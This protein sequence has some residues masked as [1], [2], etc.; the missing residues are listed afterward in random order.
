LK[1]QDIFVLFLMKF[2]KSVL[3]INVTQCEGV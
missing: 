2:G 3:Q 1:A